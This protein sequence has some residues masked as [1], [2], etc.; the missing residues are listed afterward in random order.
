MPPGFI[1]EMKAGGRVIAM[2][3]AGVSLQRSVWLHETPSVEELR[4]AGCTSDFRVAYVANGKVVPLNA[5]KVHCA[6]GG[7]YTA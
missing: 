6:R 7:G 5:M 2:F 4:K 1:K 3:R